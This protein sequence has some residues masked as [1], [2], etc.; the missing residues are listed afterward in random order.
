MRVIR[1]IIVLLIACQYSFSQTAVP[2]QIRA[3]MT[4]E[5]LG[6]GL[7][8]GDLLYGV[9][10]PPGN[11]IGDA[12]LNKT[13]NPAKIFMYGGKVI[14]GF[15]VRYDIKNEVLEIKARNGIKILETRLIQTLVWADSTSGE[16]TFFVNAAEYRE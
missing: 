10:L 9:P 1:L 16:Q 13:W 8:K 15:A 11:V 3:K 12:Y 5:G 2:T 6:N 7:S 14:D 4:L